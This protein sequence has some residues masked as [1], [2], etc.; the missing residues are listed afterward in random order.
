MSMTNLRFRK[1]EP[2]SCLWI[3]ILPKDESQEQRIVQQMLSRSTEQPSCKITTPKSA[4][5]CDPKAIKSHQG[6]CQELKGV[7][8]NN[9][10]QDN[11]GNNKHNSEAHFYSFYQSI[12]SAP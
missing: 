10:H 2:P 8:A 3:E 9:V 12:L 1:Q 7:R 6:N 5:M 11:P 4:Y